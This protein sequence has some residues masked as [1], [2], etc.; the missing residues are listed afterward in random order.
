MLMAT[1]KIKAPVISDKR[2]DWDLSTAPNTKAVM[3][4]PTPMVAIIHL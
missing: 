2:L 4:A 3:V 1:P